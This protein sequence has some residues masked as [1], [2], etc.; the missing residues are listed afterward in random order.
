MTKRRT[1]NGEHQKRVGGYVSWDGRGKDACGF[2]KRTG[3]EVYA[4]VPASV[5]PSDCG[6]GTDAV[7]AALKALFPDRQNVTVSEC[8]EA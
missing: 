7:V 5:D 4:W 8:W 1:R 6:P 2:P 3:R